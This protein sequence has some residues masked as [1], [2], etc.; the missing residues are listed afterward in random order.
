VVIFFLPFV[1]IVMKRFLFVF[2]SM[3]FVLSA[4][5]TSVL[6]SS[7]TTAIQG[8][9]TDLK[10]T[11]IDLLDTAWPF[12]IAVPVIMMAPKIVTKLVHMIGRG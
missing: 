6:D 7:T 5:A 9:F 10:D 2:F 4:Y 3:F 11:L 12:L 1:E 8:G